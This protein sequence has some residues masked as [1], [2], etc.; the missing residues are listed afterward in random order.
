MKLSDNILQP[1]GGDLVGFSGERV[2]VLGLVWLQTTLGEYPLSKISDIQYLVVDCFSPYNLILDR[3]FLNKF[4]VIVSTIHLCV[5]FPEQD[6][7]IATVYSNHRELRQCYNISMKLPNH[8]KQAQVN[9]VHIS[10]NNSVL[11]DLDSRAEFLERPTLTGELQKVYF[12]ID[13]NKYTYVG[14]ALSTAELHTVQDFLQKQVDL[15][16]WKPSDMLSID[17]QII[18]HKLA[19]NPFVRPTAKKKKRN[20]GDQKK[21]ASLEETQKLINAVFIRE[22]RFTT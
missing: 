14:M 3:P 22:I 1:S 9:N 8:S 11:A 13:P 4:G 15:F 21:K 19:I 17:P 7:Q 2:P 10:N 6:N 16:T 12:N 18:S 5:K 20:L